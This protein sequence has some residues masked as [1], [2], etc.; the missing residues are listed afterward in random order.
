MSIAPTFTDPRQAMKLMR[1]VTP[2]LLGHATQPWRLLGPV[3]SILRTRSSR[4]A[5]D[6]LHRH[7]GAGGRHPQQLRPGRALPPAVDTVKRTEGTLVTVQ[8]G[9]HSWLLRDPESLPAIMSEMLGGPLGDGIRDGLRAAGVRR[10]SPTLADVEKVCYRPGAAVLELSPPGETHKV[11]GRHRKPR[12][13][14]TVSSSRLEE[15][16]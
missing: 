11:V 15:L 2:T 8:R 5:L 4:Y 9:G 16:S 6:E 3:M 10:R 12:Y 7:R 1:L 13:S 14:W